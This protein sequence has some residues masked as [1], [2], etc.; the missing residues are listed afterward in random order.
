MKW[1][2]NVCRKA[3]AAKGSIYNLDSF[4]EWVQ[5]LVERRMV[6]GGWKRVGLHN[7]GGGRRLHTERCLENLGDRGERWKEGLGMYKCW[8]SGRLWQEGSVGLYPFI[9]RTS[10][11]NLLTLLGQ[12]RHSKL[13]NLHPVML[14]TFYSNFLQ[15]SQSCEYLE[16]SQ[17]ILS[18]TFQDT[19][20]A[21]LNLTELSLG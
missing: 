18:N 1:Q 19:S 2:Q 6:C 9:S 15:Y 20:R 13:K 21:S 16:Y 10:A 3:W 12:H 7:H 4:A 14:D 17:L 11:A 8:E 5:G